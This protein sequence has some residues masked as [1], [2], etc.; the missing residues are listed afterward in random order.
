M[1]IKFVDLE[2]QYKHLNLNGINKLIKS[3]QFVGGKILEEFENNLAKYCGTRYAVGVGS[4]TDA[5]WLSLKALG[6]G[7]GDEVLVPAN[8][9]IATALAVTH[10]GA[11]PVF[12]DVHNKSYTID[13][14]AAA[15]K[16]TKKTKAIIP[17]HLYGNPCD[18][19]AVMHLASAYNLYVVEDCAQSIGATFDGKKTGSFGVCGCFS[20][21]PAKNLG[22]LGQG[23]AVTTNSKEIA[24]EIRSL[25]NV[26]RKEG[27]WYEYDKVGFNSRLDS[28]NAWFLNE[29]LKRID[30]FNL[31]RQIAA[32]NY[33]EEL[34]SVH[35]VTTPAVYSKCNHIFHLYEIRLKDKNT[36]D[37]L[38]T[39]LR[40]KNIPTALHYPIPCHK[41]EVYNHDVNI[42]DLYV[43]EALADRLLSLPM[44]PFLYREDIKYICANIKNYFRGK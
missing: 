17:V 23:G 13:I 33:Q 26:G 9:F 22:G 25:G 11:T 41:Q 27:G 4:G 35:N 43:S 5:L 29:G 31:R 39:Y 7:P 44:H 19:E 32:A 12:V 28:V 14:G 3:G 42:S 36:R 15:R 38:Q 8:T 10:A 18:M 40:S 24:D 20:F 1:N 37:D 34:R 2:S 16:I 21:Y 30:E 6:I